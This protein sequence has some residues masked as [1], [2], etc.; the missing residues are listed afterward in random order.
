MLEGEVGGEGEE[1]AD[2]GWFGGKL[3]GESEAAVGIGGDLLARE[4]LA[5]LDDLCFVGRAPDADKGDFVVIEG[6]AVPDSS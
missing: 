3:E 5:F 1:P 6:A 2:E 4:P